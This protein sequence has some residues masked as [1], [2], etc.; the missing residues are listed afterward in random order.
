MLST[1][2]VPSTVDNTGDVEENKIQPL[3]YSS[4]KASESRMVDQNFQDI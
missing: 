4:S 3:P 2:W 1:Y